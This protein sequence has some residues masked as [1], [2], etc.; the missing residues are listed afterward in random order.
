MI[1]LNLL[2]EIGLSDEGPAHSVFHRIWKNYFLHTEILTGN[3]DL[4]I[5]SLVS[6]KIRFFFRQ[7]FSVEISYFL[8][9][10]VCQ[11]VVHCKVSGKAV[12]L[13]SLFLWRTT[14][15]T[16]LIFGIK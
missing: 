11:G 2:N 16:F 13:R 6:L 7:Y 1:F 12:I 3:V 4:Y 8:E 9:T 15:W 10:K 5:F 14:V